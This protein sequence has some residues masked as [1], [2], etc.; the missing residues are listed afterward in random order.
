MRVHAAI[1][2]ILAAVVLLPCG[3]ATAQTFSVAGPHGSAP[4]H[5]APGDFLLVGP[6]QIGGAIPKPGGTTWAFY[7][8]A[9]GA[10]MP[11]TSVITRNIGGKI[12]YETGPGP[13]IDDML[14]NAESDGQRESMIGAS[15]LKVQLDAI[16]TRLREAFDGNESSSE[17]PSA[18]VNDVDFLTP[19]DAISDT[20][21]LYYRAHISRGHNHQVARSGANS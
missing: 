13:E 7:S 3:V 6:D 12:T 19:V 21:R 20:D 18:A 8:P 16:L 11:F 15:T 17:K 4:K 14:P 9:H 5:A 1:P 10:S 2:T